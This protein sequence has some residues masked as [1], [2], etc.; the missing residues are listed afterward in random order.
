MTPERRQ[1]GRGHQEDAMPDTTANDKIQDERLGSLQ[2]SLDGENFEPGAIPAGLLTTKPGPL[3][4]QGPRRKLPMATPES[5]VCLRGPCRHLMTTTSPADL[6]N[7]SYEPVAT[8]RY[9]KALPGVLLE[10]TEDSVYSCSDWDP[11]EENPSRK[12]RQE[13]FLRS[14]LGKACAEAD[15]K[16]AKD[17]ANARA[18][19]DARYDERAEQRKL[20]EARKQINIDA[21]NFEP[22]DE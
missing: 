15:A 10:L 11:G 21:G 8:D 7:E 5:F 16:R 17:L 12:K 6:E 18:E 4:P 3:P 22:Q 13:T 1:N 20:D 9:C 19:I 2:S 14:K